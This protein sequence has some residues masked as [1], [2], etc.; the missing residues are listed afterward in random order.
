MTAKQNTPK[1]PAYLSKESRKWFG[2]VVASFDLDSH[3][4]KLLTLAAEA[5]DEKEQ[6]RAQVAKSGAVFTDRYNQPR[7]HPSI[8][9]GRQARIAFARLV[10]D[11]GLD[12]ESPAEQ[13]P[14]RVGG[15]QW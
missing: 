10:R 7:E 1:A 14:N 8:G 11:L 15:Q 6:A 9:T 13:R 5:W 4:V 3:H 2:Q 12:I